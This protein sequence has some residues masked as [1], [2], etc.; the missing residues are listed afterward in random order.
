MKEIKER[1]LAVVM[2]G[3]LITSTVFTFLALP[4]FYAFAHQWVQKR[5]SSI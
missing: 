5:C 1:P 4:T 2:T 3:G